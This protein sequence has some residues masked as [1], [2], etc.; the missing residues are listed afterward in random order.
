MAEIRFL[1]D[2]CVGPQATRRLREMGA[3]VLSV[4]EIQHDMKDTMVLSLARDQQRVLITTDKDFGDLV[5]L[6]DEPHAGILLVRMA[7]SSGRER[8]KAIAKIAETRGE[9]LCGA[10]CVFDGQNLRV[11]WHRR[12]VSPSE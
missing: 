6:R 8:A 7:N 3:D 12:G 4:R 2:A 9:E 10:F 11:R 1:I 5:F